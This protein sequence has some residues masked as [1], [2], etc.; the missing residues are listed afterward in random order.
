[1]RR[2]RG[3]EGGRLQSGKRESGNLNWRVG[4]RWVGV[5]RRGKD[6]G[7]LELPSIF[8]SHL[9]PTLSPNSIGGE[10]DRSALVVPVAVRFSRLTALTLTLSRP[11]GEGTAIG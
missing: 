2:R 3:D 4:W 11:T 6:E 8:K 10:G 9:S 7:G 5:A 1:M